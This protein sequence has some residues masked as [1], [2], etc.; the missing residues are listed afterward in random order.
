MAACIDLRPVGIR[1]D[2]S[3]RKNNQHETRD[4]FSD[5]TRGANCPKDEPHPSRGQTGQNGGFANTITIH[6]EIF[7][8]EFPSLFFFL[9]FFFVIFTGIRCGVDIAQKPNKS[10]Q[11]LDQRWKIFF[12]F[13]TKINP[14]R[15][16]FCIAKILVLMVNRKRP[17]RPRNGLG[18]SHGQGPV[19]P[20]NG[21]H[22]S[23]TPSCPKCCTS[24]EIMNVGP[25][26]M[27][28]DANGVGRN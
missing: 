15:I 2:D 14:R 27:G 18:L 7:T 11:I 4:Q 17:V 21:S 1:E 13:F 5:A 8:N 6:P 26:Q 9:Y 28:S 25:G 20:M 23:W 10:G 3:E 12:V 16:F 22:L 24:P 19:C